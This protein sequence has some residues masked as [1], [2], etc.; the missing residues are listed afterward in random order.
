M[1]AST[2]NL[3]PVEV[4]A[5]IAREVQPQDLKNFVLT[6]RLVYLASHDALKEYRDLRKQYRQ[7]RVII[8]SQ[9][10][11]ISY[12][13]PELLHRVLES[14]KLASHVEDLSYI[15]DENDKY[16]AA[17][18][19]QLFQERLGNL[20]LNS[21][22]RDTWWSNTRQNQCDPRANQLMVGLLLHHL[23]HLEAFTWHSVKCGRAL[24]DLFQ[25]NQLHQADLRPPLLPALKKVWLSAGVRVGLVC[26]ISLKQ[27]LPFLSL[28]TIEY[29]SIQGLRYSDPP[30]HLDAA[31][32]PPRSSNLQEL[33]IVY[34]F[35][36]KVLYH[37]LQLPRSL[38][39]LHFEPEWSNPNPMPFEIFPLSRVKRYEVQHLT[40]HMIEWRDHIDREALPLHTELTFLETNCFLTDDATITPASDI[41]HYFPP[42]IRHIVFA[43]W[44]IE[45][46]KDFFIYLQQILEL[47]KAKILPNLRHLTLRSEAIRI[48]SYN[49]KIKAV[50]KKSKALGVKFVI[51]LAEPGWR[52]SCDSR[53]QVSWW[54]RS[55]DGYSSA[56]IDRVCNRESISEDV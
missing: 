6:C 28:P 35:L 25:L 48:M 14:P 37:L 16:R 12:Y 18:F 19:K 46:Q 5:S 54:R 38:R 30:D 43:D 8:G 29:M 31:A 10:P 41:K 26:H 21:P 23:P 56:D 53:G 50:R 32:V 39:R 3:L 27:V 20:Q 36:D 24:T 52:S 49:R 1:S 55:H 42:S 9:A 13:L 22:E 4:L 15:E 34:S 40:I 51:D 44:D 2:I 45:R 47:R 17:D 33:V 7:V 11:F